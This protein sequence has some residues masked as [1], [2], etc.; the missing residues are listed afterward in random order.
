M[1][2]EIPQVDTLR[3]FGC[4]VYAHI[5]K[6]ERQKFDS[7]AR[8]CIFLG[9][10]MVT[11][12][13]R[14]YDVNRSK[15]LYSRDVVFDESKPVVEKEPKDEQRNPAEQEMYL[16]TGSGLSQWWAKLGPWMAKRRRWW[17]RVDL[18]VKDQH[19]KGDL[20]ICMENG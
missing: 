5:P 2:S 3:V 8:R 19:V 12:G 10:G 9:Y 6:D 7:K 18:C 20:L 11:K 17:T 4:L 14:L 1:T 13:Y 15:V 16:D